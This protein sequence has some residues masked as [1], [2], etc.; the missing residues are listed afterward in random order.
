MAT[1]RIGRTRSCRRS[2]SRA[3]RPS[4][5]APTSSPARWEPA[6]GPLRSGRRLGGDD[7]RHRRPSQFPPANHVLWDGGDDAPRLLQPPRTAKLEVEVACDSEVTEQFQL[8][9]LG[10]RRGRGA[11]CR[12]EC[13]PKSSTNTVTAGASELAF[14]GAPLNPTVD[15]EGAQT[16]VSFECGETATRALR[17]TLARSRPSLRLGCRRG[18]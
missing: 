3:P 4:I 7:A 2:H 1:G 8:Q 9:G 15:R 11:C 16:A 18:A 13:T 6:S 5:S 10:V 14:A 12:V 17:P